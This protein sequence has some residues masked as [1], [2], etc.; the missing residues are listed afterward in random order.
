[1]VLG[2]MHI[3]YEIVRCSQCSFGSLLVDTALLP[4][5]GRREDEKEGD[6]FFA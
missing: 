1:M 6:L 4:T 5:I 2:C 3:T